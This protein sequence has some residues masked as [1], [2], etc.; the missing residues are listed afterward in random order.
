MPYT[1]N[2]CVFVSKYLIVLVCLNDVLMFSKNKTWI[3]VLIKS[4]SEGNDKFE[5]TNKGNINKCLGVDI[6]KHKDSST[7]LGNHTLSNVSL[8]NLSS[9]MLVHRNARL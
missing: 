3:D 9:M 2:N 1:L 5:L 8:V 7:T 4:L 6:K